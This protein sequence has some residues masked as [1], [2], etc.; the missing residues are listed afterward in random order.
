MGTRRRIA[1]AVVLMAS[2][3]SGAPTLAQDYPARAITM[4]VPFAVGGPADITGRIAADILRV[5]SAEA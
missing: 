5:I 3:L 1:A 4:I 2:G